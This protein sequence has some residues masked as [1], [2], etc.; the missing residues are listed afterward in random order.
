MTRHVRIRRWKVAQVGVLG[1]GSVEVGPLGPGVNVIAGPN[2]S[3]KS[4]MVEALRVALFERSSFRGKSVKDLM[5]RGIKASPAVE[6]E[7]EIDG[8]RY[9]LEKRLHGPVHARLY[10]GDEAQPLEN[11]RA[12]ERLRALLG[13]REGNKQGVSEDDMGLWGLLWVKQD[14]FA[15]QEPGER[16]GAPVREDLA[17]AFRQQVGDVIGGGE[18]V[19]LREAI[20]A[21]FQVYY[22]PKQDRATGEFAS[23]EKEAESIDEKLRASEEALEEIERVGDEIQRMERDLEQLGDEEAGWQRD[24]DKATQQV[25]EAEEIERAVQREGDALREAVECRTRADEA[26]AQRNERIERAQTLSVGVEEHAN[27]IATLERARDALRDEQRSAEVRL[28][29]VTDERDAT[30]GKVTELV[31]RID[32]RRLEDDLVRYTREVAEARRLGK[33]IEEAREEI[34]RLPDD[35]R[36]KRVEDLERKLEEQRLRIEGKAT[37]A[38]IEGVGVGAS[39]VTIPRRGRVELGAAGAVEVEAPRVGFLQSR[40]RWYDARDGL[41]LELAGLGA[42]SVNELRAALDAA[43]AVEAR[44][45]PFVETLERLCP[46][47][48]D[49]LEHGLNVVV[50]T[51][52]E[53]QD[54]LHRSKEKDE[55]RVRLTAALDGLRVDAVLVE[56]VREENARLEALRAEGQRASVKVTLR[57]LVETRVQFGATET[58][59]TMASGQV[60]TRTVERS[61]SVVIDDRV[62]VVIDPGDSAERWSS[63]D[64]LSAQHEATWASLGVADLGALEERLGEIARVQGSL[65]VVRGEIKGIGPEGIPSLDASVAGLREEKR[66]RDAELTSARSATRAL[67]SLP[68][69]PRPA[70]DEGRWSSIVRLD[71]TRLGEELETRRFAGR[72]THAEGAVADLCPAGMDLFDDLEASVVGVRF[73]LTLGECDEQ[74]LPLL[75]VQLRGELD[76]SGVK[77]VTELREKGRRRADCA[78]GLQ[79]DIENLQRIAPVGLASLEAHLDVLRDRRSAEGDAAGTANEDPVALDRLRARL[80]ADLETEDVRVRNAA[81]VLES[82]RT[83]LL[84]AEERLR[85]ARD[86]YVV[87]GAEAKAQAQALA[88]ERAMR[89]DE[90]LAAAQREAK[91]KADEA[92]LRCDSVQQQQREADLGRRREEAA[93][94]QRELDAHRR[95]TSV[96]RD[97]KFGKEGELREMQRQGRYDALEGLRDDRASVAT[98]L[99]RVR[100]DA[101]AVA[102]LWR[103]AKEEYGEAHERLLSPVY[104]AAQPLLRELW[105]GARLTL[106]QESLKVRSVERGSVAES[107]GDLSGGAREQ[108]AVIVRIAMAKVLAKDHAS[109][110]LILDDILGWTDDAR[111]RQMIR[112][113]ELAAQEMQVILL[114]CHPARFAR[115]VHATRWD[116]PALKR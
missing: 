69:P 104:Q 29:E 41:R 37:R 7:L 73:S 100:S 14:E 80:T 99:A 110:P 34:R 48:I 91:A 64:A 68:M 12:D 45:R 22:T 76:A 103:L 66:E 111:L 8:V 5:P 77:T 23:L 9:R 57:P 15:A 32:R 27:A 112:V 84:G 53:R 88:D 82:V 3:G 36:V 2:E 33:Q 35:A 25:R 51:L 95:Q 115:F 46:K 107:F 90:A 6:V 50:Q 89:D 98:K 67:A 108:L 44:R 16:L 58:P 39:S 109:M 116:L 21:R 56:R 63:I 65:D 81:K 52:E 18:G 30:R 11:D 60:V 20:E 113:I 28:T 86:E 42:S 1:E 70:V 40:K 78:V 97:R 24:L 17:D 55:E 71:Q 94:Y 61:M 85:E 13:S 87:R 19:R 79:R 54:R 106:D 62:E 31:E 47:G 38:V 114:T 49:A 75:D 101:Q 93:H 102:L 4:T 74:A 59:R 10:V 83:G 26:S 96:A 105:P 72:I 92:T 43:D